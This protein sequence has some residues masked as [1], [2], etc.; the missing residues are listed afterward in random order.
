MRVSDSESGNEN[1]SGSESE[2]VRRRLPLVL[3]GGRDISLLMSSSL[4]L[5]MT[6][7]SISFNLAAAWVDVSLLRNG[8]AM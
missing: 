2:S 5:I 8:F 3:Q 7:L 4:F 1:G 6:C